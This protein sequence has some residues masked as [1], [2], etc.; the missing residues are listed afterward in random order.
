MM[1][2]FI[3]MMEM[4]CTMTQFLLG[5]ATD[6][7]VQVKIFYPK[8]MTLRRHLYVGKRTTMAYLETKF[9]FLRL[10]FD[11]SES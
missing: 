10:S 4:D 6:T 2:A 7:V 1:R 8:I 3:F 11:K 9:Y 5:K